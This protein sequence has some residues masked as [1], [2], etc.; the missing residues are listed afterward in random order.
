MTGLCAVLSAV[1]SG[2]GSRGFARLQYDGGGDWY[3][4]PEVLPNLA[5]YVNYTLNTDF[6]IDQTIVKGSDPRIFDYPFLYLTGH[7]NIRFSERELQNLRDWMLRG[8]FLYADDDYG[9]DAA[10][11]REIKRIFPEYDL[12]ELDWTFPL[13]TC[14]FDFSSGLPKIHKHDEKPPRAYGIFDEN[15]R[16]MVFYTYETNITDGWADYET[17]KNP[18]HVRDT[19]LRF[20]VNII[21]YIITR[22]S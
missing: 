16:L 7:G 12:I 21:Y 11:R 13:F 18:Q 1:I 17:H 15:G 9:M 19:S 10:F 5:R 20:G 8:G 4:N 14:F 3:N 6:P 22:P 2:T